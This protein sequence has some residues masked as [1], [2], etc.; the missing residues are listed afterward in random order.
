MKLQ[1]RQLIVL[2]LFII[3]CPLFA[4]Q[5]DQLLAPLAV[6]PLSTPHPTPSAARLASAAAS[7]PLVGSN[8]TVA[9]TEQLLLQMDVPASDLRDLAVRLRPD[10]AAV[11]L[12][13]NSTTPDYTVGD[14]LHFWVQNLST[15][16]TRQITAELVHKTA[17]GYAW[18]EVG[19]TYNHTALIRAVDQFSTQTYPAMVAFFGSEWKPGVD[20]DPRLHLLYTTGMGGPA[21]YFGSADEYSRLVNPYSNEKEIVYINLADLGDGAVLP[22]EF[23]HMIHRYHD[24]N[25]ATWVDEGLS[26]YAQEV[27]GFGTTS[28]FVGDFLS[29]PDTPLTAWEEGTPNH[30]GASYLFIKYLHQ[31]FGPAL[32]STLVAQPANGVAGVQQALAQQRITLEFDALFADWVV[33]NYA[34]QPG[35][36]G[37]E[38]VYGY[39]GLQFR[40]P[41]SASLNV[42]DPATPYQATVKNYATDYLRLQGEGAVTIHFSGQTTTQLEAP[43]APSGRY[44][45]WSNQGDRSDSR[46]TRRFDLR[47]V[48][49]GT[50]L[51]L[52][53]AMWWDIEEHYDYGYVLASR[54]GRKWEVLPGQ[55][56][57]TANPTGNSFG[58]AYTGRPRSSDQATLPWVVEHFDLSR[59]AGDQIW[60]RFEYVTD[61]AVNHSGWFIDDVRIPAIH[62]ATDF[63]HGPNGWESEGWLLTDNQL[64]QRWLLQVLEFEG[65][66]LVNLRRIKVD[67]AGRAQVELTNLSD[68]SEVVLAI[69]ALAPATTTPARYELEIR[70]PGDE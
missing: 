9:S 11:P 15:Q 70:Q 24:S 22:H 44:A 56:T 27:A 2:L 30:Y 5:P 51:G 3:L 29:Q 69:S 26:E 38:E 55:Q 36:L 63:E 28:A 65:D 1:N 20:N 10:V 31:R 12:V 39:S 59:Y 53:V 58:P 66:V 18:V 61:D 19:P 37:Q 43:L 17:V 48:A 52:E 60:V 32:L 67:G 4:C 40:K 8:S 46:L 14:Q 34:N 41:S 13:V 64:T 23:Q 57:T 47:P 35:T 50:L 54:D 25:E 49:P 7:T 68:S 6:S 16:V 62:Y 21:G 33:A 42:P 45:W